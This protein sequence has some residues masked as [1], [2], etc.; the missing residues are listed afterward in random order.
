MSETPMSETPG[1]VLPLFYADPVALHSARHG[2]WRLLPGDA[3]P[4]AEAPAV[5]VTAS[6]FAA[7]CGAYPILF[8][9]G[10]GA[11]VV[12]TGLERRNLFIEDG[13]WAEGAY[14]PAYVRRYPFL[15]IEAAD[16]SGWGLA[17]DADSARVAR[18]GGKGLP[19]F[20]GGEP[21]AVTREALEFCRLFNEDH[22]RT[23]AFCA[24]VEAAGLLIERRADATM[25]DGRKLAVQGFS[26]IDEQAFAAL[27]DATV[28]DWHRKGWLALVHFH[29]ASLQRFADLVRRQGLQDR[30]A[31]DEL[32]SNS[33]KTPAEEPVAVQ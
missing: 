23:L 12:L 32:S 27:D 9:Q 22:Q 17:I 11:P 25:P 30:Q 7:A 3:Q 18:R 8:A 19:L 13:R 24:A 1:P 33:A 26:V 28:V 29:L 5:P 15:L 16:K 21:S 31:T 6:E 10:G 4:M 2:T 20:E 14:V